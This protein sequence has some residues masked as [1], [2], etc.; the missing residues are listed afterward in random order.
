MAEQLTARPPGEAAEEI[1]EI[2]SR[3]EADERLAAAL[4]DVRELRLRYAL[5]EGALRYVRVAAAD[6]KHRIGRGVDERVHVLLTDIVSA[7]GAWLETAALPVEETLPRDE[8]S[9]AQLAAEALRAIGRPLLAA[10]VLRASRSQAAQ[11]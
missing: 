6:A 9:A 2:R 1:L 5:L 3:L 4:E 11:S 7:S 8:E 10:A